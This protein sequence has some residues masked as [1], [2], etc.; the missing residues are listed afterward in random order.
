MDG[1]NGLRPFLAHWNEETV[2]G[3]VP[4]TAHMRALMP[5]WYGTDA[6]NAALTAH[7]MSRKP[8]APAPWPT[9]PDAA[10]RLAFAL[11]CG[12][13][14]T[15]D[16]FRPI[17]A[18][19]AGMG[20]DEI[21]EFLD[22]SG[23][24][25][26]EMP[27]YNGSDEQR[28]ALIRYLTDLA[29]PRGDDRRERIMTPDVI[30]PA[31]DA[32]PLP[33]PALLLQVLLQLTFLLH[34][35]AMNALLG[36]L[37]LTLVGR[38]R[39]RG[40]DDP[41]TDLADRAAKVTPTL[42]AATVTLGVAPLLFLQTLYGQ[43]FFTSSILMG[44]GWF[45]IIV[46]L[47]FAYYGTYLQAFTGAKLGGARTP[48]LGLVVLLFLWIGFMF[49][50][51]TTLMLNVEAWPGLHF[52]SPRGLHLNLGDPAARRRGTCTW[53]PG[54]WP[55]PAFCSHGGAGSGSGAATSGARSWPPSAWAPSPG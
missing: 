6:E 12:L 47:I 3:L 44:W 2:A 48:L 45:S 8:D 13:C 17:G 51:N 19:L 10:A 41:W 1:Y 50:N 26:D 9:D 55:W 52:A 39:G 35:V 11:S 14:H 20:A 25:V 32:L 24:L 34:L 4:R 40:P 49:T 54:R 21:D 42:V 46:V 7:L 53:W 33:A 27:G 23:D 30:I 22:G 31:P 16:G 37:I 29:N 5:P 38:L 18:S 36:G 28:A 15:A 43:F